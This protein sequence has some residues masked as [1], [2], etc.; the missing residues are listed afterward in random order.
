MNGH[1]RQWRLNRQ[2]FRGR[3]QGEVHW[4]GRRDGLLDLSTPLETLASTYAIDF[5]DDDTGT[6]H[7]TG[8]RF[9][10]GGERLLPLS[11]ATYNRGGGCWQ[12]TGLGGQSSLEMG[13]EGRSGHEVNVFSGRCRSMLIVLYEPDAEGVPR[14]E[15][16]AA[17]AFRC[18]LGPPDPPRQRSGSAAELLESVRGWQ[19][20]EEELEPGRWPAADPDPVPVGPFEPAVFAAHPLTG[21]FVDDQV[22]SVPE[23]IEQAPFTLHFGCRL[24][25]GRFVHVRIEHDADRRLRR[26]RLRRYALTGSGSGR[27]PSSS[28]G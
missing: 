6:W 4:Y 18:G 8:L 1:D 12:F 15:S 7:G 26:W 27:T 13:S 19:G 17:T 24:D 23:R 16:V 10:P 28:E 20:E 9:A 2:N 22:F 25:A 21:R 14:L 5:S 3:W 11:R